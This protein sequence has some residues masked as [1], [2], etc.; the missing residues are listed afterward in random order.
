M[1]GAETIEI[2]VE[3][4]SRLDVHWG[5]FITVHMA[6]L[7][8]LVYID[9][10]LHWM[11]KVIFVAVYLGFALTNYGAMAGQLILLNAAYADVAQMP[12]NGSTL[13]EKMTEF[14]E[15]GRHLNAAWTVSIA[16][17]LMALL[18]VVTFVFQPL[19]PPVPADDA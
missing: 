15:S 2:A 1:T 5:L 12:A 19:K 11:E 17:V 3:I 14:H 18:V 8:A 9:N 13:I 16:H 10:P 4:G 7:G 6:M